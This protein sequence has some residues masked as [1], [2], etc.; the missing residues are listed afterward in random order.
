[1]DNQRFLD[2]E[3]IIGFCAYCKSPIYEGEDFVC[4]DGC[5][6]HYSKNNNLRNCYFP[7]EEE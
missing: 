2:S 4:I 5:Y 1:M 7:E 3:K 6:Y